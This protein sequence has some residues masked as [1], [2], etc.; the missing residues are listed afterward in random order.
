MTPMDMVALLIRRIEAS[1]DHRAIVTG[2]EHRRWSGPAR[3]LLEAE[4]LLVPADAADEVRC[5]GCTRWCFMEVE[6][7]PA[8]RG[9]AAQA[10]VICDKCDG[11]GGTIDI[12]PQE[13]LRW[14]SH[15][16]LFAAWLAQVLG[17][18]RTPQPAGRCRWDLGP[19]RVGKDRLDYSLGFQEGRLA[20]VTPKGFALLDKIV[21]MDGN[22]RL[23][24][25]RAM[26]KAEIG[27]NPLTANYQ[28]DTS[29]RDR[30]KQETDDI[31]A[32][33]LAEGLAIKEQFGRLSAADICRRLEKSGK[34]IRKAKAETILRRIGGRLA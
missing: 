4:R 26:L 30:R 17:A 23:V 11:P 13:L 7:I 20:L 24:V 27:R 33:L 10:F 2:P 21:D 31:Y 5:P 9:R 14:Q 25:D 12:A 32:D 28:P 19:V 29:R 16:D 22:G 18:K 8:T 1:A 6:R 34:N 15:P 3:A